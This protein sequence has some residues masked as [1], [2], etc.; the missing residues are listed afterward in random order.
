MVFGNDSPAIAQLF[1]VC[2]AGIDHRF[3]GEDHAGF[4]SDPGALTSVMKY[5]W[6]FMKTLADTMPA[7]FAHHAI[8]QR[9]D[10]TLDSMT[11]IT[12]VSAWLDGTYA[13][14]HRLIGDFT[15]TL[16]LNGRYAD[17]KHAAAVAVIAV[18]D[19]SDVQIDNVAVFQHFV[20]GNT[21][22]H[23]MID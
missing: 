2:L 12:Q 7:E 21:V 8:A 6:F 9:L 16:G 20:A 13:A 14:P 17:I 11:D 4:Q 23:L 10:K 22:T 19:D 15:Q 5:L 18:F 1:D 3:D